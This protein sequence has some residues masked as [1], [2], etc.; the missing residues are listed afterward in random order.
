MLRILNERQA[1]DNLVLEF[2]RGELIV[3]CGTLGDQ[4][5]VFV[6]VANTPRPELI[7]QRVGPVEGP[8]RAV[9]HPGEVVLTF[10]TTDQASSVRD[11]L[12]GT[13]RTEASSEVNQGEDD[14]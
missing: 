13:L 14:G 10:P 11:A 3:E 8:D 12:L 1:V 7:G 4:P 5:A 2:G 6:W 9:F